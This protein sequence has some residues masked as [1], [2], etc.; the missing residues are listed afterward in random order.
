MSFQSD[1]ATDMENVF[2]ADF[3]HVAIINGAS[4]EGYLYKNAHEFGSLDTNQIRFDIPAT[5]LPAL[6][7]R[8]VITVEGVNY[9]YITKESNGDLVSLILERSR[10]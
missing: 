10:S 7:R 8:T 5:Q 3:K 1:M 6:E 4:I 2:F 9:V